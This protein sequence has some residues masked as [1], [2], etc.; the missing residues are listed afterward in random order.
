MQNTF[1]KTGLLHTF[2]ELFHQL[3]ANHAIN[4]LGSV[5]LFAKLQANR[6][7]DG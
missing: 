2:L 7:L 1:L 5:A 4:L 3:H 6:A